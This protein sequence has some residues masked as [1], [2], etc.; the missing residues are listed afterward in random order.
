MRDKLAAKLGA[1]DSKIHVK[2]YEDAA[3]V[4]QAHI[5]SFVSMVS[6]KD[7]KN[8]LLA[9]KSI[10]LRIKEGSIYHHWMMVA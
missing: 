8:Y 3:V 2:E 9:I 1:L 6:H 5:A 4:N 7:V 10:Y